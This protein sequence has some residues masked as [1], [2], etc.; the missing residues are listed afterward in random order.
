MS[1]GGVPLTVDPTPSS[2]PEPS[3]TPNGGQD[4]TISKA[5]A[6]K[7][8]KA[9][10]A[11]Q[12]SQQ[13]EAQQ[14]QDS[15]QNSDK[16]SKNALKRAKKAEKTQQMLQQEQH[17]EA[18]Q[19]HT[20]TTAPEPVSEPA[21]SENPAKLSKGAMKRAKKA[22]K[23]LQKQQEQQD[24]YQQAPDT[25]STPAPAPEPTPEQPSSHNPVKQS[26]GAAKRA[27]KA[28][29][30]TQ[31][32]QKQEDIEAWQTHPPTFIPPEEAK[33]A[34]V[35]V[36]P[37]Q[38]VTEFTWGEG[39]L[40]APGKAVKKEKAKP[41][42]KEKKDKKGKKAQ[43]AQQTSSKWGNGMVIYT[44]M[45]PISLNNVNNYWCL[46]TV[47]ISIGRRIKIRLLRRSGRHRQILKF[48]VCGSI[49]RFWLYHDT[50][51]FTELKAYIGAPNGTSHKSSNT[52]VLDRQLELLGL[53][54][55]TVESDTHA[56][57]D[58][59]EAVLFSADLLDRSPERVA[60]QYALLGSSAPDPNSTMDPS[61]RRMFLNTNIPFSAFICGVQGSGKSHT[62]SCLIGEY[63]NLY[64][65]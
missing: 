33:P 43:Q 14:L 39:P 38:T 60:P 13:E 31:Q 62:T 27:K 2:T 54:E 1:P 63:L 26:K 16:P 49:S 4:S 19:A 32:K 46:R 3:Q 8:K 51:P 12:R 29:K 58:T 6:K 36:E 10:K 15:A 25:S 23:T 11:L 44:Q 37:A 64:C 30:A 9:E 7:A 28:E 47:T 61:N 40:I 57:N 22:E 35:Y 52:S 53:D 20:V 24:E 21:S 18:Q 5:A 48:K 50:K 45:F 59:Q 55:L 56:L 65:H 34:E 41:W 17:E 42:G